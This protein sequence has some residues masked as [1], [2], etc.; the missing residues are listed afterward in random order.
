MCIRDSYALG[1]NYMVPRDSRIRANALR[2]AP[3]KV[4]LDGSDKAEDV[5]DL[6][7]RKFGKPCTSGKKCKRR[8]GN[9]SECL[10]MTPALERWYEALNRRGVDSCE[11]NALWDATRGDDLLPMAKKSR[12]A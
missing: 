1:L 3:I 7:I 2:C 10:F 8:K 6:L 4:L 9:C 5:D 11:L 12:I